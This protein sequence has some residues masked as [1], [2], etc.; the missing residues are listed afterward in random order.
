MAKTYAGRVD[1]RAVGHDLTTFS[2]TKIYF[3]I[4]CLLKSSFVLH[5][6][7]TYDSSSAL[8]GRTTFQKPS[9]TQTPGELL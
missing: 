6:V 4:L 5:L 3:S 7:A 8:R 1:A 2:A 9:T